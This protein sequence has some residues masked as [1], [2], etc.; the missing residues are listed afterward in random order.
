[1]KT[2]LDDLQI[3]ITGEEAYPVF[4]QAVLDARER[5]DMGFR[6]FDP[7]TRLKSDA[8]REIG[9][10]WAD[11]LVH[12]LKQG[13]RI[14]IVLTDFD[15][16]ARPEM[17][18]SNWK[19]FGI[20]AGIAELA[21]CDAPLRAHV[22]A[23]PARLAL[24]PRLLFWPKV[25]EQLNATCE[26]LNGWEPERRAEALRDMPR[27]AEMV[28]ETD[29]KLAVAGQQMPPLMPAT[30]H[31]KVAVF[32]DET[33][34][35]GGLDLDRRRYDTS[36]HAL[37][38]EQSWHDVQVMFRDPDRAV[39]ARKH[40]ERFQDECDC[41]TPVEPPEGL[42]RT[43]SVKCDG[44]ALRVAPEISDTGILERHLECIGQAKRFIYLEDQFFRDPVIAEALVKRASEVPDLELVMMLPAAPMEV[45]FEGAEGMDHRYGE[46]MQA[47]CVKE[48][49]DAFGDRL[50]VGAPA[51]PKVS[52][53]DGR[54]TLHGAP[55]I[56]IH[57]KVSVFDDDVGLVSSANL[58]GRSM[59]WDTEL[60]VEL[61]D[62]SQVMQLRDRTMRVWLPDDA[63][64]AMTAAAPGTVARWWA[65][66]DANAAAD[67][68]DR[69]G[70]VLPY[71]VSAAQQFGMMLP[72]LPVEMV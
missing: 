2:H 17:H 6:V 22:A 25:M 10:T 39:S 5:I 69:K 28:T 63:D 32:D 26:E 64:E 30:H 72:G 13:V 21:G 35:I 27:F 34:Y 11:L 66:A 50:F 20:L 33:L 15:P 43:L 61:A 56:F 46:Y 60:G 14:L 37:P 51:K 58:N 71:D 53:E 70:F 18:R 19:S 7:L 52:Q 44:D 36:E 16:V 1:M 29:G 62:R 45:A 24:G 55:M 9:E 8:A 57:S 40:L 23:H 42:I 38:A 54:S 67:P 48:L 31:Q 4:E 49:I 68:A 65:L 12:K 41:A 59:R 3:L 47:R